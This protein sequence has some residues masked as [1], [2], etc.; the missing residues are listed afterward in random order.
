MLRKGMSRGEAERA[1]GRPVDVSE[2]R[3][4]GLLVTTLAFD[5]GDQRVVADFVEDVLV[6]YTVTSK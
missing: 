6:K 4:G 1:F 2:R 3:D 5:V